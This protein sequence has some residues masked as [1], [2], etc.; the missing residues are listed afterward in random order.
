LDQSAVDTAGYHVTVIAGAAAMFSLVYWAFAKF[1]SDQSDA[2]R[3]F[4]RGWLLGLKV[5][6]QKWNKFFDELFT[7]FFGTKHL[8]R[9]CVWRSFVLSAILLTTLLLIW[10]SKKPFSLE[11]WYSGLAEKRLLILTVLVACGCV[12]DYLSLWKTRI[13]LINSYILRNFLT[14]MVVVAV[15]IV[16]TGLVYLIVLSIAT[17][18]FDWVAETPRSLVFE[19]KDACEAILD[20]E[21][22]MRICF[23]AALLTSAWLW[24]YLITAY[25]LH[26]ANGIPTLVTALSKVLDFEK[27]PVRTI[28]YVPAT[29]SAI[30]VGVFAFV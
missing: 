5:E 20:P 16:A 2:N 17:Y 28:G 9:K 23:F 7:R 11:V 18:L 21:T 8:S 10:V 22:P 6:D 13:L 19:L 24:V 30:I 1:D 27:H 25:V 4:V 3:E 29:V 15:D 12:A 14:A 26:A